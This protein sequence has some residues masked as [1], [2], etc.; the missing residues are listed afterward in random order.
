MQELTRAMKFGSNDPLLDRKKTDL[1]RFGLG[2][3]TA[4][5]S[6]C[7]QLTV[8]SK[9]KDCQVASCMWDL[10]ILRE[11]DDWIAQKVDSNLESQGTTIIWK[12][13]DRIKID[14]S[15]TKYFLKILEELR[16]HLAL[17]FHRFIDGKNYEGKER[18][19][20]I[21]IQENKLIPVDPFPNQNAAIINEPNIY[22]YQESLVVYLCHRY[23]LVQ[24]IFFPTVLQLDCV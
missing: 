11:K 2:L 6:Q 8:V 4:S 12:K 17:T 24:L 7:R 5:I 3:K 1:G 10:D 21:Y 18:R 15:D 14:F 22:Q 13:L 20:N 19:I 23:Q 16:D 9:K